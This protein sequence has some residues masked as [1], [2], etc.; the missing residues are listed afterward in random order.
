MWNDQYQGLTDEEVQAKVAEGQVNQTSHSTQKTTAEIIIENFFT[1]FNALNFLLAFLLLLVGAYSNMA[2]IA[3]IILNIIIG[4]VQELR[5]RDLVSKLTI[6]SNKPVKVIRN[7]QEAIVPSTELVV[8]DLIILESGDQVPSDANVVDGSSEVNESLL[9]GESDAILKQAGDE[10]LSGSYLTSGQLLA[11]LIH[12]GDDNYAEQ[13][14]AETKSQPYARS[15]LT[16]AI[17]KIAKFTS[18]IIVPLGILLFLQA[19]FLRSDT[20]DVAVINSV[21]ALIGMLPKGLV[22]LIS[23]AL[24][25]AVLKLG[26]K[27]VLVQNMY[28][29]EALAHMDMLCLDKTGTITQGKMSVEGIFP[30]NSISDKDLLA[31]LANYTTASTDSNLTMTALK[32]HFDGQVSTLEALQVTPFSSERKWGAISFEGAGTIFVGAAEYLIDEPIEQVITAQ[33]DGLRVLL[34]GQSTDLLDD[35][36]EIANLAIKPIGYITLSDPIRPNSKSTL[37]FFQNEGVDIK[38]ISGDNPQTVARV[39]KNA[40]LAGDAQA[41]DMS[42]IQAEADVRAAAHQYN[43]FGR[44]SPQ[45]KKLLVA[46]F[47]DEDHIVGM[48][49][50]GVNDILALSQADL[51]IA[52]AEGD[53]ATRQMADLILVNSDFGDLPAVIS[54]GRRVVNNI[55][56]SSSVFFIKTL[57]SLI[58]TLI[59]IALN[60]PFPFIPLQITMID[61]F[62]EG[63]PAFFTSFEPNNQQVK[64]RF[65]PKSLASALPSA[66]TVSVAIFASLVM[67]KLGIIDFETARTFDYVML[68]GVSLFAV[69]QSCL[70][71]NKLRLFLAST[72]TLAMLAVALVLPHFSDILTIQ[73]MTASETLISVVLLA[74]AFAFWKMVNRYQDC[75]KAFFTRMHF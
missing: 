2:F 1:L 32:D 73:P 67:V 3:I 4:I 52:M 62:I 49:G 71:F 13:L 64:E 44:V 43:V 12:V 17:K 29:V 23:L 15:E 11:E 6:L 63:Y 39:A 56:R 66:L 27:N 35:K 40:G 75:F 45:Q 26:K 70:P 51:S 10:L 9:T 65:L 20:V 57:Y 18:Y 42:Q 24:S 58:V 22:L 72:A 69:W 5:A 46:E 50:D 21:A 31:K 41:I 8:G 16:D 28:A 59:C 36:T 33:N 60:F 19:F 68:T 38:I 7:R 74:L 34:V 48:T 55:T 53:G 37:E 30:L 61:A 25:T 47:Q 14:V 54:E